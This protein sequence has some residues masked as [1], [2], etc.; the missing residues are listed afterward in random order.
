MF[1]SDGEAYG[2]LQRLLSRIQNSAKIRKTLGFLLFLALILLVIHFVSGLVPRKYTLT[3]SGGPMLN[4]RHQLVRVL[5]REAAKYGLTLNIK[6]YSGSVELLEAVSDDDVDVAII[7]GGLGLLVPNVAHVATLPPEAVHILVR[8]PMDSLA[9]LRGKAVN[10]GSVD[11]GTRVAAKNILSFF[12]L[13]AQMDYAEKNYTNEQLYDMSPENLPDA[14]AVI[15]YV[16]SYLA[17]Y[18]VNECGYSLLPVPNADSLTLR[19]NWAEPATIVERTYSAPLSVPPEDLSTVGINPE[20]VAYEF[21][22]PGA[23]E[24]LLEVLYNSSVG[25]VVRQP[26]T[27]EDGTSGSIY[28]LSA[29]SQ[30][31]M[32][33][34]DPV[35][36]MDTLDNIKNVFG[37]IMAGLSTL[38]VVFK[39]FKGGQ[40][41]KEE[42]KEAESPGGP[43]PEEPKE[44]EGEKKKEPEAPSA[45]T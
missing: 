9:D 31:Y 45:D 12:G 20:I 33:R 5:Q 43:E 28:P 26:L 19:Y 36:S 13:S 8:E 37:S 21:A 27:E 22:D 24:K 34:N 38:L 11:G 25:N 44:S 2:I 4:N 16:P 17:D 7:Q 10:L 3:I 40:K 42:E 23:I 18:L 15:S 41:K 35:F 30:Y 14:I 39:W 29:G 32:K 6:P 1:E